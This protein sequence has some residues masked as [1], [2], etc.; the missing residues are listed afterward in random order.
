MIVTFSSR[1]FAAT[2]ALCAVG[3]L[4]LAPNAAGTQGG[5]DPGAA[6]GSRAVA[7][8]PD[9]LH[10]PGTQVRRPAGVPGVPSV[11]ALSWVVADAH[12]GAV[13]AA[14]DAHR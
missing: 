6:D 12:S 9:P 3:V 10:R 7:P 8:R 2:C 13:L 14:H 1:V 5:A 4:G 11:S